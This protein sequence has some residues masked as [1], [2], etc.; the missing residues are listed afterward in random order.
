[1]STQPYTIEDAGCDVEH[2][3]KLID[4]VLELILETPRG[5]DRHQEVFLERISA[6]LWIGRD[7][8]EM[9]RKRCREAEAAEL[10]A[11]REKRSPA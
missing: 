10:Q 4:T 2:L 5:D 8:A 9:Y 7:A 6:L 3:E 1:M 11:R